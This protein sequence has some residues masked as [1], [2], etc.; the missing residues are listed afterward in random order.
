MSNVA[1]LIPPTVKKS[2]VYKTDYKGGGHTKT[3]GRNLSRP[4]RFMVT[5]QGHIHTKQMAASIKDAL[6][7]YFRKHYSGRVN[8]RQIKVVLGPIGEYRG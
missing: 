5:V 6:E 2:R 4:K 1:I 8:V 3:S 7:I